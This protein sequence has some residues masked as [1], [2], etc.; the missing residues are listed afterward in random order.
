VLR[1][2]LFRSV[3]RAALQLANALRRLSRRALLAHASVCP[4][5]WC[6]AASARVSEASDGVRLLQHLVGRHGR[7]VTLHPDRCYACARTFW[8]DWCVRVARL[9]AAPDPPVYVEKA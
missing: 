8:R 1:G 3:P 6:S 4:T 2:L 5:Y 9:R 7:G